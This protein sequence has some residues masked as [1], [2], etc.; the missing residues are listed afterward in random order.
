MEREIYS[1]LLAWKEKNINMPYM[2]IG[3]R[4]TGKT[5]ILDE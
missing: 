1:K 5:Y 2:L 4:Q 3:V